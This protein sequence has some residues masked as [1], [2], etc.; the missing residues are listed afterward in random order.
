MGETG[1][2][3]PFLGNGH[4]LDILMLYESEGG[5]LLYYCDKCYGTGYIRDET[6]HLDVCEKC[7][8][9]GYYEEKE[10]YKDPAIYAEEKRIRRRGF[11][12]L[13]AFVGS[14]YSILLALS[15]FIEFSMYVIYPLVIG[16]YLAGLIGSSAYVYHKKKS[17]EGKNEVNQINGH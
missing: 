14:V 13:C 8:G 5:I 3:I 1:N 9:L 15:R 2:R 17:L 16:T 4:S 11:I 6:D 7:W 12:I 10:Q